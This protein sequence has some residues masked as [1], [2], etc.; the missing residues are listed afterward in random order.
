MPYGYQSSKTLYVPSQQPKRN[1]LMFGITYS[2][3]LFMAVQGNIA[4]L[5]GKL[6]IYTMH[7][8]L[9]INKTFLLLFCPL[10]S[11]FVSLLFPN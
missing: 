1:L 8:Y 2:V 10:S 11:V 7:V 5:D 9:D 3:R 6:F 4:S